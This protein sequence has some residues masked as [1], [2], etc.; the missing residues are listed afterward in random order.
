MRTLLVQCRWV[1]LVSKIFVNKLKLSHCDCKTNHLVSSDGGGEFLK[2]QVF[3]DVMLCRRVRSYRPFKWSS[4][5]HLL[6]LVALENETLFIYKFP[7]F[8]AHS[9]YLKGIFQF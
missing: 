5:L 9:F 6:G 4:C 7:F 1:V 2:I 8:M 3:W